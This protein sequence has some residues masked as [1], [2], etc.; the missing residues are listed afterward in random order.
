MQPIHRLLR[1]NFKKSTE[2]QAPDN[3]LFGIGQ[4]GPR[5]LA[6]QRMQQ[7]LRSFFNTV[8]SAFNQVFCAVVDTSPATTA[9]GNS[10]EGQKLRRRPGH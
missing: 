2:Y 6:N 7:W 3:S 8:G 9:S 5:G 4:K 1:R 10:F